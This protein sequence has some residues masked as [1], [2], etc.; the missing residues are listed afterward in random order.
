MRREEAI[1]CVA[2]LCRTVAGSQRKVYLR[3]TVLVASQACPSFFLRPDSAATAI[4][5]LGRWRRL[6]ERSSA[7]VN[8][9]A[10][11]TRS[12]SSSSCAR[13]EEPFLLMRLTVNG[14][15]GGGRGGTAGCAELPCRGRL[16]GERSAGLA[17]EGARE[18]ERGTG[19]AERTDG[20]RFRDTFAPRNRNWVGCSSRAT[21][22][23]LNASRRRD[24]GVENL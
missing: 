22:R 17:D 3:G 10:Q 13:V 24:A 12:I 2:L 23:K 4:R 7:G 15:R 21:R 9:L 18:E 1:E 20:R 16:V 19:T 5:K 14:L 11:S 6:R 8:P